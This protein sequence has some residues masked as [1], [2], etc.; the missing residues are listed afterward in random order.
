MTLFA[1]RLGDD[2]RPSNDIRVSMT[3][4]QMHANIVE[5]YA[6]IKAFHA[7]LGEVLSK[8]ETDDSKA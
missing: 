8:I 3:Y 1:Q 4:G 2:E 5:T 6:H 7:Q